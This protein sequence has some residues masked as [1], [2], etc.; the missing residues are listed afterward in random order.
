[1]NLASTASKSQKTLPRFGGKDLC[2]L[3]A[4]PPPR[5]KRSEGNFPS[6][7]IRLKGACWKTCW[8]PQRGRP[9]TVQEGR[10]TSRFCKTWLKERR[11]LEHEI[12]FP[13]RF[14]RADAG[15]FTGVP[16]VVRPRGDAQRHAESSAAMAEKINPLVGRSILF[17]DHRAV[18]GE[19]LRRTTRH[20]PRNV[21]RGNTSRTRKRYEF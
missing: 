14:R 11:A 12:A 10:H 7:P 20:S 9:P 8:L 13:P 1:M 3:P 19:L 21:G 4:C 16:A 2:L 15:I 6:C 18:I 17:I 5:K